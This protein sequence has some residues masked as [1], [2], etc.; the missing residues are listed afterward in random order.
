MEVARSPGSCPDTARR[1][2]QASFRRVRHFHHWRLG[3]KQSS[4][5]HIAR[6]LRHDARER[7]P[8]GH[9]FSGMLWSPHA[10]ALR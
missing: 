5:D 7:L 4:L 8:G 2:L 9:R 1:R 6:V 10:F 3:F